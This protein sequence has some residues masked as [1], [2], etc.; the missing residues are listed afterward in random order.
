MNILSG[1]NEPQLAAVTLPAQHALIL[2]GAGSGKTRVLTTRIAW[3]ISTNQVSPPGILAVTFTNKAAKEM[4]MR[5]SAMLPI[6]VKGMWIGTF[7]GLC[8]R[9]LRAHYRDAGLPQLF[10]ILDSGDQMAAV[11]RL[12]K[13]LNVDDEKFPPREV[14]WFINAQKEAGLRP[15]A[16]EAFDDWTRR[17]VELYEAYEGQCQ[18]EGVVDFSELLLRCYELLER[19]EPLRRH[20]QE[21]FRHVLVDEFQDTNKLQYLWLKLLAGAGAALFCVGDDDQSIYAFR[22]ADVGN[23]RDF[24]REFKVQN[25]IRLEQNYR[26]HGNILDAANAIIKNNP[27]RLGKNLWTE[28]GAGEPIRV[29]ESYA[30]TDEARFVVDEVKALSRDGHARAEIALLYRSNAQSR[31][32]EHA[33]FNAGLPYRVYGGLRF[34]ER[35]EIKHALAYLR[36]IANTN[37]DTAFAR[38]L[39]FP[40]RG[41]GARSLEALQDAA[42]AHGCSLHAAIAMVA[43]AG[44]A[45]LAAFAQLIV[46]LSEASHLP[47]PELVEHVLDLSGLRSHYQNEKEGQER[48]ANLDE[49]VNAAASFVAEEGVVGE[50]GELSSDLASFLAHAS[51]EAGEHQAGEGDDALQLMTVHSAKGLEFNVVFICGLEEGL[52]PHENSLNETRDGK[53]GLEEERRLMYVA[54]TR[55]RQRLYL[56]FAQTRMLHGQT[57][58]NLPSRFLDEIP[59]DLLKYLTAR[60]GKSGFAV[61]SAP[62]FSSVPRRN[63]SRSGSGFRI[64]QSVT[65]PKFG[66]GVIVNAEGGGSDARVQVNFGAAG[67][68]WLALSLAKLEAV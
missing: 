60:A 65:H 14:T 34:F 35:A 5:L 46:K 2:A 37:D 45:K 38:V 3:L 44:G 47:L 9:L 58:Y 54:V 50:E 33:L 17:R 11:K 28:A 21:R 67:M 18:R 43:G 63:G 16:V 53:S 36:L 7:H 61:P 57:R 4:Q 59:D 66:L 55:A 49:L 25:M 31:A 64:G 24:E 30:E 51:L 68:K 56:C 19:N 39:N 23:M 6:N 32:L 52:F 1:L 10:Q 8:N 62:T 13:S 27:Q 22:G 41:I 26:S 20:Y 29:H 48:L 40:T 42:K 12:L 15:A